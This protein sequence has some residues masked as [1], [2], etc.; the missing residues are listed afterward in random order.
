MKYIGLF[1]LVIVTV[2]G[3]ANPL[4]SDAYLIDAD[5]A[6]LD[7]EIVIP[8]GGR[9]AKPAVIFAGGSSAVDFRDYEPGY[10]E[11]FIEEVFLPRDIAVMYVNKRGLGDSSGNWR[12]SSIEERAEDLLAAMRHLQTLSQIDPNA[13]G[14]IG[15][16]QG[17]WVAQEAGSRNEGVAFVVS[18]AG[19]TV[20]VVE[21]DT[22]RIQNWGRC[23][24][25]S[26]DEV[27]REVEKLHRKHGRNISVGKWF[28]FFS[29][30]YASNIFQYDPRNA[31]AGL[32]QP[33]LLAF[34]AVDPLVPPAENYQRIYEIFES[35]SAPSHIDLFTVPSANHSFRMV[36][37]M[38]V[39]Y[40]AAL[41]APFSTEFVDYLGSWIDDL[42]L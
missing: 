26:E 29:L 42:S 22:H 8:D 7:V 1:F 28:P 20:S 38:C 39:S 35:D 33:T 23:D 14:L 31:I 41:D 6:Q 18:L 17:G 34:G 3:C 37:S 40:E 2:A 30:R 4:L 5:G 10:R 21:Q 16:S 19:P 13:I 11:T 36:D 25:Q 12:W 27:S 24:G 15:H 32:S 9:E